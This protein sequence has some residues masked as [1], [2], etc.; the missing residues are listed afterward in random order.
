MDQ[1]NKELIEETSDVE[2]DLENITAIETDIDFEKV[3]AEINA[4]EKIEIQSDEPTEK[5]WQKTVLSYLHDLV[6][7]L[8]GVL[9]V[10]MFLFRMVV[11]SGPSMMQTLQ[12]GDSL[13]L[14]SNVIYTNPK[15]GDIVVASKESFKN[16][17]PIIKRVIATEG[18]TVDIDFELG[19]VYVDGVALHESYVNTPTNLF[20]GT[21]FPLVVEEGHV[22]V[23]GDNRND[24]MDS[25][26]TQIGQIDKR[27]LLGKAI[28]LVLPGEDAVT[29]KRDFK[30]IGALW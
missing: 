16:G 8:V 14:L 15:Y 23:L 26:S 6:F 12:D 7:G 17:E 30:R 19:I 20:E 4:E 18:Q 11:V 3:V 13:I 27:E 29:E 1:E 9:V 22:F 25:R 24:S 2:I 21:T 5:D 10:F 28:F